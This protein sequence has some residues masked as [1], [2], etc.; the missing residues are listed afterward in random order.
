MAAFDVRAAHKRL[1]AEHSRRCFHFKK[2]RRLRS[3]R[4]EQAHSGCD[5]SKD[6]MEVGSEWGVAT[7][8]GQWPALTK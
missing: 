1:R 4:E 5:K 8:D 2:K 6:V 7:S 3:R